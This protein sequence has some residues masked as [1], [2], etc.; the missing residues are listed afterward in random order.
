M[1]LLS[2]R[3]RPNLSLGG[4]L[5]FGQGPVHALRGRE[6]LQQPPKVV[7]PRTSRGGRTRDYQLPRSLRNVIPAVAAP[8]QAPSLSERV[9]SVQ[10]F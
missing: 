5:K 10:V 7:A 9:G 4:S 3:L 2:T 8:H 6:V 1:A